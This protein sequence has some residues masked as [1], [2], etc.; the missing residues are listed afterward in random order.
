MITRCLSISQAIK[1]KDEV[2]VSPGSGQVVPK[3][4]TANWIA[5]VVAFTG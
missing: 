1:N 4:T 3:M 2:E 5:V